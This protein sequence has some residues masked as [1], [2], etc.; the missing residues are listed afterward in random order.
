MLPLWNRKI[1]R[2]KSIRLIVGLILI[3][4]KVYSQNHWESIV[5]AS[6]QWKYF[7]ATSQPPANWMLPDFDDS[8][9]FTGAGGFGYGDG[10]DATVL[11]P[12]NSVYIR[13][14]FQVFDKSI[15]EKLL[16]DIDYD[17]AFVAYLNGVE[18]ARSS[19]VTDNPPLYNSYVN[20]LHEALM[21]SGGQPERYAIIPDYL[22]AGENSFAVQILNESTGSSDLTGLVFLNAQINSSTI[23]YR[24]TPAWFREPIEMNES[25]LPL[26]VINTNG[27]TIVDEPKITASLGIIDNEG[28]INKLSDPYTSVVDY[29]GIEIRGSSSQMFEKKNFGFETRTQ[30]GDNLNVSLL[31]L[32][33]ENDWVLHGPYS[34]KSLMR[35][36]L[37]YNLGRQTGWWAPRTRF[38]ELYINNDYRGVYLLIEKI[39]RDDNRVDISKL[40]PDETSGND[41]T[42][43]YI[44]SIDRAEDYWVSPYV[45]MNGYSSIVINYIYPEFDEMPYQQR[46]YIKSYVTSFETA[47]NSTSFRDPVTGY[48]A[49]SE[50]NSFIDYFLVSELSRNIDSYRLSTF[51]Y[52]DKNGKLVMGPLWDFNLAFG[53]ADYYEGYNPQ[54]WIMHGVSTGDSYQIPFW[55]A[56]LRT[57]SYFNSELKKRW[58][59]L[60]SNSFSKDNIFHFIDSTA[61]LLDQPQQ[62]NFSRFPTLGQYVWPNYYIGQ[63]Y[64]EEIAFLKEWITQRLEWMD[65]QIN[66]ITGVD[67]VPIA[68]AYET[69]A[70][71]NPFNEHLTIHTLIY[72][73]AFIEVKVYN[74]YGLMIYS[75]S[76]IADP[77]SVDFSVNMEHFT[78]PGLYIFEVIADG[79]VILSSK[80]IKE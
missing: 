16:L 34:D 58:V 33:A 24:S 44:L 52:K 43:G 69:Y 15:I 28:V 18:I 55:W 1:F 62:R 45:G 35:N 11:N 51:F 21:Y 36:A 27:L 31:G 71:P 29:I 23:V 76:K 75:D 41:L 67:E 70:F 25:Y 39:K 32:P 80:I 20:P 4:S 26:L 72:S 13:L 61:I 50:V 77:G 10:D 2:V 65:N 60:R 3:L 40:E 73:P 22:L 68:N 53:N 30:A 59:D 6:D 49:Y 74:V 17:D 7:P 48:R 19:N 64:Q 56:K 5:M 63:T 79:K 57:D 47:L 9:W 54:G 46:Q 14:K 37:T 38:C 8:S 66:L 12:V 78:N 42:G